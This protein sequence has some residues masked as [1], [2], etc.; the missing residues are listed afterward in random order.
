[1]KIGTVPYINALPLTYKLPAASLVKLTPVELT[2]ALLSEKVDVALV[3]FFGIIKHNFKMHPHAGLIGCDGAIKSAGFFTRPF[4][5]DLSAIKSLYLDRESLTSVHLAKILLEKFYGVDLNDLEL[6]HEDN[7][8]MADA[9]MLIGDKALFFDNKQPYFFW[10]LGSL[11]QKHTACGF[12]F[13]SWASK[14]LLTEHEIA[15]LCQAKEEG[16]KNLDKIAAG[17]PAKTRGV[18][19]DYLENNVIF[20]PK[21]KVRAGAK[22][23]KK[24]L[25]EHRLIEPINIKEVA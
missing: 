15:L 6:F 9:H 20:E 11:W 19:H 18:V 21:E 17:F 23:F 5:T 13:A 14:R 24:F 10:D 8:K 22:L 4:I 16:L 1:M 7:K 3:P 2:A 12:L 25:Q